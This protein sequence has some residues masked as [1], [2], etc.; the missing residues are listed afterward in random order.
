MP[1]GFRG[2]IYAKKDTAASD[3]VRRFETSETKLSRCIIQVTG[4][5]QSFGLAAVYPVYFPINT[6]FELL[7]VDLSTLYFANTTAGA[8]GIVSILGIYAE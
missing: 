6:Q 8:N 1:I 7:N 4:N 3:A 2:Q 5:T